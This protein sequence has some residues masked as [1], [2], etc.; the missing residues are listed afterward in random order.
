LG[1]FYPFYLFLVFL[2][3]TQLLTVF[4]PFFF[5]PCF[6]YPLQQGVVFFLAFI[7]YLD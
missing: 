1:L 5:V 3:G 2:T 7:F 6:I 4:P